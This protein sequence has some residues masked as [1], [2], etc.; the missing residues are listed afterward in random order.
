M[1]GSVFRGV[2]QGA[3]NDIHIEDEHGVRLARQGVLVELL[4]GRL[5]LDGDRSEGFE[6]NRG[7]TDRSQSGKVLNQGEV[8]GLL[9]GEGLGQEKRIDLGL[10][11]GG[12]SLLER[13]V[14]VEKE[15]TVENAEKQTQEESDQDGM[16]RLGP[17]LGQAKVLGG[18]HP[19]DTDRDE[20]PRGVLRKEVDTEGEQFTGE[21]TVLNVSIEMVGGDKINTKGY[22][23]TDVDQSQTREVT[24]GRIASHVGSEE[25]A[26]REEIA[27]RAEDEHEQ[28]VN[29][30]QN[31]NGRE[32][33]PGRWIQQEKRCL[34]R[35]A[36]AGNDEFHVVHCRHESATKKTK[37]S[38]S[39]P[40]T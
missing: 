6:G 7:A 19:I 18:D 25:H 3:M 21:R 12:D 26:E 10:V 1:Q 38:E 17:G 37:R 20:D 30:Q 39:K 22:N 35:K 36:A 24:E 15:V 8:V 27:Q 2:L 34:R 40:E 16:S 31:E 5:P 29:F 23:Y 33:R 13:I 11:V 4:Q 14:L 9:A 32:E 28:R